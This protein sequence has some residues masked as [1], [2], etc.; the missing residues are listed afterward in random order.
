MAK[1]NGEAMP[2][3]AAA[4]KDTNAKDNRAL[5]RS[6]NRCEDLFILSGSVAI[7]GGHFQGGERNDPRLVGVLRPSVGSLDSYQQA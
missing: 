6:G 2:A 7:L 4:T 3:T 1:N 5:P